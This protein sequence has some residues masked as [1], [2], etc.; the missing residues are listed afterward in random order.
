MKRFFAYFD[1]LGYKE[2]ILKND[3]D[4]QLMQIKNLLRDSE[5]SLS[6]WK[7]KRIKNGNTVA[8]IDNWKINCVNISDTIIFWTNNNDIESFINLLKVSHS[9][10]TINIINNFLMRGTIIYDE[11]YIINP[12]QI[13]NKDIVFIANPMFGKGLVKAYIKTNCQKW[14]GCVIDDSVIEEINKITNAHE[15]LNEFAIKYKVPY[16]ENCNSPNEYVFRLYGPLNEETFM[17]VKE[18]IERNF[19]SF[20]KSTDK[21]DVKEKMKN[22]IEF[23]RFLI[24]V[25]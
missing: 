21:K 11:F 24:E 7:T 4:T 1:L 3:F 10:C 15:I 19:S 8:D 20:K 22:T 25:N 16:K 6:D 13:S 2:F 9:F 17:N 12:S 5:L 14:A 18:G 23:L